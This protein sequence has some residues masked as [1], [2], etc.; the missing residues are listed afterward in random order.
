MLKRVLV[1]NNHLLMVHEHLTVC[2]PTI[3]GRDPSG[4]ID[5]ALKVLPG[6]KLL[7]DGR[8][9]IT[10]GRKRGEML[11]KV[12]T[13]YFLFLDD[14]DILLPGMA[15]A[16][17]MIH[18]STALRVAT[19][20]EVYVNGVY[21]ELQS[22][23]LHTSPQSTELARRV[24]FYDIR[25]FE[26]V[27]FDVEVSLWGEPTLFCEEPAYRY[28]SVPKDYKDAHRAQDFACFDRHPAEIVRAGGDLWGDAKKFGK[29]A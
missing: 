10:I 25:A 24:G 5:S 19:N 12:E 27:R 1:S 26:D 6:S 7:I 21:Q 17:Q 2:I 4:A 23:I 15:V 14:D 3:P 9:G 28:Y 8:D 13:P 11:D 16:S 29:V 20:L 22:R 18:D